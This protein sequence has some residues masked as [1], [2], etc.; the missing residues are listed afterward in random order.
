[1]LHTIPLEKLLEPY[2]G[3]ISVIGSGGK[4]TLLA[5]GGQALAKAGKTVAL[6]TSTHM[7]APEGIALASTP[8]ELERE[9]AAAGIACA[10]EV[11]QRTGKLV[12]PAMG[13]AR[14]ASAADYV[15]VEADG[16][17]RLPLKAHAPH[18]PVI[19]AQTVR[20]ILV[21]GAGG[22]GLPVEQAVH[23]PEVFCELA[24][25][26][27]QDAAAPE[28]V[29]RAILAE[30]LVDEDDAV[31]IN[32][33]DHPHLPGSLDECHAFARAL[34]REVLAGS[35]RSGVLVHVG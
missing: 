7:F 15:L 6:A 2:R 25:C 34:G 21:V 35:I 24:G 10:G 14:L 1:M 13:F 29:A 22:F 16:S 23:R 18:E 20:T 3:V 9:L 33:V 30:G 32:Q 12:E 17:H 31:V 27:P 5:R 4:S 8:Q 11:E 19:P 26:E 28:L